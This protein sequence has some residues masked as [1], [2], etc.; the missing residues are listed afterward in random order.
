[1]SVQKISVNMKI[2]NIISQTNHQHVHIKIASKENH[3][4]MYDCLDVRY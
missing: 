2:Y 1:M 4:T 3:I